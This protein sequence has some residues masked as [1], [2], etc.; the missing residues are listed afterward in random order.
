MKESQISLFAPSNSLLKL[1]L[2][3]FLPLILISIIGIGLSL[4]KVISSAIN[5]KYDIHLKRS[6]IVS[7][8][9]IVFLLH[10]T[11]TIKSLSVFLCQQIDENDYRMTLYLEYK[12]YSFAHLRWAFL[13]GVPILIIWVIGCPLIALAL[14]I[15]NRKRLEKWKVKKYFL[16]LYQGLKP[17]VF[18]WEIVSTFRKFMILAVNAMLST[19]SPN[20]KIFT[21]VCKFS[22]LIFSY[23]GHILFNSKEINAL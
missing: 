7:L 22:F 3:L 11:L 17:R 2:F 1:F 15:K 6:L 13:V 16:I 20:F 4:F 12:C 9:G 19:F 8:I 5:P 23:S 14:L 18:Y 10:P 21:S